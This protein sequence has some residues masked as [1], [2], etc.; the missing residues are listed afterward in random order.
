MYTQPSGPR[1]STVRLS[2]PVA[3]VVESGSDAVRSTR[4][5]TPVPPLLPLT[6]SAVAWPAASVLAT[7]TP[8]GS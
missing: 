6:Y 8:A 4:L 5:T 1:A 2:L 3:I 7:A